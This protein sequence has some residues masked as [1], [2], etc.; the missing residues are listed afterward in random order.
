MSNEA[1]IQYS[2]TILNG[3]L[4]YQPAS[5]TFRAT[6]TGTKGPVPGAISVTTAGVDVDFS[7]LVQPALCKFTNLDSTN[8]VSYG[9]WDG[10]S[11]YP[12]GELLP[13]ESYPLRLSRDLGEEFGTG[14]GTTGAAI[15]KLRFKANTA[16]CDV[17][18]EA[19]ES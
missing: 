2:L 6:V 9:I 18:I 7:E 17:S 8:F 14:T 12:L 11:F 10:T 5:I 1:T 3:N 19:F 16:T 4:R 13:G 15:N